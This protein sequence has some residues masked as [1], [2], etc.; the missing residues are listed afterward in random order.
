LRKHISSLR[1]RPILRNFLLFAFILSAAAIL[2]R[3]QNKAGL[4]P[5][6]ELERPSGRLDA[7]IKPVAANPQIELGAETYFQICMAC[8]GDRGQGLTDEW[9]AAWGGDEYC[10]ASKCHA[11]NHPPQGFE[12]PKTI[13]GVLTAG[14]L[15]NIPDGLGL[16][17]NNAETMP[18]WDPGSLSEEQATAVTAYML[19]MR[20]ELPERVVLDNGNAAV[21]RTQITEHPDGN[22]LPE[23]VSAT[24]LL[25]LSATGLVLIYGFR[26]SPFFR[27]FSTI[28]VEEATQRLAKTNM[29]PRQ[30]PKTNSN[31]EPENQSQRRKPRRPSFIAHLH[32]ASIPARESRFRY[33]FGLGGISV[34]LLFV[35]GITGALE[36]FHYVPSIEEA[37]RSVQAITFLIPFGWVIRGLHFWSAQALVITSM[38]HLLRI[39][40]TGAYK[41]PRRFNWLLGVGLLLTVF[42]LNFTGYVLRW[43]NDIAWAL[44]V[45]TNLLKGIPLIGPSLYVL[46]VGGPE[47]GAA[48]PVRFYGWHIF[49]LALFAVILVIWHI[50]RVRRDG[51]ISHRKEE[52]LPTPAANQPAGRRI[53]RYELLERETLA[54]LIVAIILLLLT[55]LFPPG[56]SASADLTRIPVE[57]TAPW[58]FIWVQEL[59]RFGNPL[60][61]GV[62]IP[63]A[64]L[65]L[66][67]VLPFWIDR[68]DRG[69]AVWFNR[70]GRGAQILTASIGLFALILTVIGVL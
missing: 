33:T 42:L 10:W 28:G 58:F 6:P 41:R 63:A 67:A 55:I 60:L 34:L 62:L 69:S 19:R 14:T 11:S 51:G 65:F 36:L 21:F 35:V 48:T 22:Q 32:P 20:G 39:V 7:P 15:P 18:W 26:N 27:R 59:L 4:E 43:D 68:S 61:M 66:I 9:R 5:F 53:S 49:G 13:P 2:A 47:I 30:E 23:A 40:L 17:E 70:P 31:D 50:F 45:G 8:H 64:M 37:N 1:Y 16:L 24:G 46:T 57:A 54:A 38:L 44:L 3:W 12:L 29:I 56:L 25:L 52:S